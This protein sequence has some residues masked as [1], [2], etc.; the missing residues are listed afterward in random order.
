MKRRQRLVGPNGSTL[1]AIE[2]LT[3]SYVLVQGQTVAVMGTPK[4]IKLVRFSTHLLPHTHAKLPAACRTRSSKR[5]QRYPCTNQLYVLVRLSGVCLR[6]VSF[7]LRLR[8]GVVSSMRLAFLLHPRPAYLCSLVAGD[9]SMR[10]FRS[11]VCR[12]EISIS[13]SVSLCPSTYLAR[14]QRRS[15]FLFD[16]WE[17]R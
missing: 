3:N 5:R 9:I 6:V 14:R 12:S 2:L 13:L 10:V 15:S 7:Q 17:A 8:L 11:F 4:G 1:K 16:G